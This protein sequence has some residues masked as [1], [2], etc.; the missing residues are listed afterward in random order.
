MTLVEHFKLFVDAVAAKFK[1]QEAEI[2]ALKTAANGGEERVSGG[3]CPAR[4]Y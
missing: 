1:A 4:K 2:T 3:L